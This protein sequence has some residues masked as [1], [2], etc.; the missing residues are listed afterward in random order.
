[1]SYYTCLSSQDGDSALMEAAAWGN[2]EIIVELVKAGA[3]SNLRNKV[4]VS[5]HFM[6][7]KSAMIESSKLHS[8]S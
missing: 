3:N 6:F 5:I 7:S 8:F 2:T 4:H 1:M